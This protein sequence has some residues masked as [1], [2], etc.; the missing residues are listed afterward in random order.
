MTEVA[1]FA[2]KT[3]GP[4]V[5]M[6]STLTR[7]NS[8]AISAKRSER[9]SAQRTSIATVRPSIQPSSRSRCSK[10]ATHWPAVERVCP[11]RTPMVGSFAACC[12][13]AEPFD[14]LAPLHSITSSARASRVAGTSSAESA[15]L[16]LAL[17]LA[18]ELVEEAPVSSLREDLAGTRLD[19]TRLAETQGPEPHRVLGFVLPPPEPDLLD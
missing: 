7:T 5:T 14:E 16:A 9:P 2:A 18:L 13:P 10:A 17:Q 12:A 3:G 1:C 6:T 15:A 11:L 4:A 8:A 19:D